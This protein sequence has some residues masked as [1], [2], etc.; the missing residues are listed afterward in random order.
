MGNSESQPASLPALDK[1]HRHLITLPVPSPAPAKP[2]SKTD[3]FYLQPLPDL[4][5]DQ[6]ETE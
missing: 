5:I 1:Q 2:P 6:P 4:D 3:F